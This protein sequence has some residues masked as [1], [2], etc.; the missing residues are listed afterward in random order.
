MDSKTAVKKLTRKATKIM[1]DVDQITIKGE[2]V[3]AKTL[4]KAIATNLP[5]AED[6]I[7][8]LGH[9]LE[10]LKV[11]HEEL[12]KV[13]ETLEDEDDAQTEVDNPFSQTL[14]SLSLTTYHQQAEATIDDWGEVLKL[15][16]VKVKNLG[17]SRALTP[18][19]RAGDEFPK[20][21]N[22]KPLAFYGK[23]EDFSRFKIAFELFTANPLWTKVGKMLELLDLIKGPA[24]RVIEGLKAVEADYDIAWSLLNDEYDRQPLQA[25]DIFGKLRALPKVERYYQLATF[26]VE[27][28]VLIRRMEQLSIPHNSDQVLLELSGKISVK[29]IK[30]MTEEFKDK[31]LK[32]L[33]AYTM[34][35]AAGTTG[36]TAPDQDK[37]WNTDE[38]L[39]A[40]KAVVR[41][42]QKIMD[43][44]PKEDYKPQGQG[45]GEQ[46]I[47]QQYPHG[48]NYNQNNKGGPSSDSDK[49]QSGNQS[50]L[51][52]IGKFFDNNKKFKTVDLGPA[53]LE[54]PR[55]CYLCGERHWVAECSTYKTPEQRRRAVAHQRLCIRCFSK[56]HEVSECRRTNR[57]KCGGMHH[58]ALCSA[59]PVQRQLANNISKAL[60]ANRAELHDPFYEGH[61]RNNPSSISKAPVGNRFAV[62]GSGLDEYMDRGTIEDKSQPIVVTHIRSDNNASLRT[63]LTQTRI[64]KEVHQLPS[65]KE[66]PVNYRSAFE[67]LTL[68]AAT[69]EHQLTKTAPR[70]PLQQKDFSFSTQDATVGA[71]FETEYAGNPPPMMNKRLVKILKLPNDQ[72]AYNRYNVKPTAHKPSCKA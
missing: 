68:G 25:A 69:T 72:A 70:Q 65:T 35:I 31:K 40:L 13:I 45:T 30:E 66:A 46:D 32:D 11:K 41:K 47:Y 43:S 62:Y 53:A 67:G 61:Q 27:A 42:Q 15:Y 71:A 56:G 52:E 60:V 23:P 20:P 59:P 9:Q 24:Q 21:N 37:S 51:P 29:L 55:D 26:R 38:F 50:S 6:A 22:T 14:K 19:A 48:S 17:P 8:A 18:I 44:R 57:C 36:L 1:A 39:E 58:P 64:I 3:G 28:M 10:N 16:E 7:A 54:A 63:M 12:G 2:A 49:P 4:V 34:E 33:M 5:A